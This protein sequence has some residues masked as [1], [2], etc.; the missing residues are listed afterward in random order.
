MN[1]ETEILICKAGSDELSASEEIRWKELCQED[2]ELEAMAEDFR[3]MSARFTEQVDRVL[4]GPDPDIVVPPRVLEKLEKARRDLFDPTPA[5]SRSPRQVS[6][7]APFWQTFREQV[8]TLLE[9]GGPM[10]M[11][12]ALVALLAVGWFFWRSSDQTSPVI[13]MVK[14]VGINPDLPMASPGPQTRLLDPPAIWI[15][16]DPAPVRVSIWSPDGKQEL[17][18]SEAVRPPLKWSQMESSSK[19]ESSLRPGETYLVRFESGE[20]CS[21]RSV[22][23]AADA[24]PIEAWAAISAEEGLALAESWLA[25]GRAG[26]ALALAGALAARHPD[27]ADSFSDLR[28]R[29][30]KE[31]LKR[32]D[33]P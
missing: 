15:S 18:R 20:T 4:S 2:P 23:V 29:S 24:K 3:R 25:E 26:D 32:V 31:A 5:R 1:E 13:A 27:K 11:A 8:K 10:M 19:G 22:R 12:T 28:S 30:L 6:Q 21:E 33:S 17:F 14:D 7:A 9:S 16:V